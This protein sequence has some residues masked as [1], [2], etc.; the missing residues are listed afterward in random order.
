MKKTRKNVSG[1]EVRK[2]QLLHASREKLLLLFLFFLNCYLFYFLFYHY[3][4]FFIFFFIFFLKKGDRFLDLSVAS[5]VAELS[6]T[7]EILN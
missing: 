7:L 4:F 5:R 2:S 1:V 3:Y 6:Q